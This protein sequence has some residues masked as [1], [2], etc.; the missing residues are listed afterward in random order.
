M[1]TPVNTNLGCI[2]RP[3]CFFLK[4]TD[5]HRFH[6]KVGSQALILD[7]SAPPPNHMFSHHI[8]TCSMTKCLILCLFCLR[9]N[10]Q[11][12]L[13]LYMINRPSLISA[14]LN[15][16]LMHISIF[17]NFNLHHRNYSNNCSTQCFFLELLT[18]SH[19]VQVKVL[20]WVPDFG[21][22]R[23]CYMT[24]FRSESFPVTK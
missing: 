11:N 23:S 14:V 3:K 21:H 7:I 5:S 17:N 8:V 24:R 16:S 4:V 6:D 22:K 18:S 15:S 19:W 20:S 2:W 12:T 10:P 13:H 1:V 9:Q